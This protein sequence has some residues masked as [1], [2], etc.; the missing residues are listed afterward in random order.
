MKNLVLL[1]ALSLFLFSACNKEDADLL[2]GRTLNFE[3]STAFFPEGLVIT[4]SDVISESRCPL[5]AICF[6]EGE[7]IIELEANLGGETT[8]FQLTKNAILEGL[9]EESI[10]LFDRTITLLQVDP[11][12]ENGFDDL[13]EEYSIKIEVK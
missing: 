7:V 5:N 13:P 4:F 9:E 1:S 10:F 2:A 3:Q 8:Q 6:W 11:Y 12:P